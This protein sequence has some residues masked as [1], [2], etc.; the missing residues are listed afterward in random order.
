MHVTYRL[1]DLGLNQP[2]NA[3]AFSRHCSHRRYR[4]RP[5]LLFRSF[6]LQTIIEDNDCAP[7][8][9]LRNRQVTQIVDTM[10]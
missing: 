3:A 1:P 4:C 10:G 8:L 7:I 2:L 5:L 9:D 6:Q